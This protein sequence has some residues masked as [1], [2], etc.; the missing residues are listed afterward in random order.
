MCV[1][2]YRSLYALFVIH[3][4]PRIPICYIGSGYKETY[5]ETIKGKFHIRY[6][7]RTRM[8]RGAGGK[9][10]VKSKDTV[11]YSYEY[12]MTEMMTD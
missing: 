9:E 1:Y 6:G 4:I 7:T 3:V 5:K 2:L 11:R 12:S 8:T 10:V